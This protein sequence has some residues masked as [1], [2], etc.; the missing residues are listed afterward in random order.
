LRHRTL[1]SLLI[2]DADGAFRN[3]VRQ[4]IGRD[5]AVVGDVG[6]GEEA[7]REARRLRPD[8]VLMDVAMARTGGPEAARR[9]KAECAETR[10]VLLTAHDERP[11]SLL[12]ADALLS[13]KNM[14]AG[15]LAQVA[16]LARSRARR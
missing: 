8:V 11:G 9:I 6:D 13:K 5:I 14:R 3:L 12:H 15:I 2:A 4:H 10:V 7:V 1:L 16:R